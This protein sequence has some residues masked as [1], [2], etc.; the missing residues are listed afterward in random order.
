MRRFFSF[1]FVCLLSI[2]FSLQALHAGVPSEASFSQEARMAPG[3]VWLLGEHGVLQ[4][5]S[6]D[7]NA[8]LEVQLPAPV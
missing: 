2:S 1:A 6:T 8:L 4:L 5:S 3:L 7:G